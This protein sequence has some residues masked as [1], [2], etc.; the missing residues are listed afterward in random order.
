M[1]PLCPNGYGF[2]D[3]SYTCL[4]TLCPAIKMWKQL[5][6]QEEEFRKF[7]EVVM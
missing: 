1:K 7:W 6:Q 3:E 2:C 4:L 5:R